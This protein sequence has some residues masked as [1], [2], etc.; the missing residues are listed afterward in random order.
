MLYFLRKLKEHLETL[1]SWWTDARAGKIDTIDS[2]I[3]S[4]NTNWTATRAGKVDTIDSNIESLNTNWTATRAGH[5]DSIEGT[6]TGAKTPAGNLK[7]ATAEALIDLPTHLKSKECAVLLHSTT[8]L[9][10]NAS[11]SSGVIDVSKYSLWRVFVIADVEGVLWVR[12]LSKAGGYVITRRHWITGNKKLNYVGRIDNPKI[13]FLYENMA[14][15]QTS[16][17]ITAEVIV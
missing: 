16:F 14:F 12:T 13:E 4:L 9:G 3:G 2:N 6:L 11:I 5:L 17:E 15:A 7:V 8:A 10:A 1:K